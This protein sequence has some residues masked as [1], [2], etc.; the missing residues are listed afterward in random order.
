MNLHAEKG[1]GAVTGNKKMRIRIKYENFSRDSVTMKNPTLNGLSS[2][3][4]MDS[5]FGDM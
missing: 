2:Q 3:I 5:T 4:Q 1:P